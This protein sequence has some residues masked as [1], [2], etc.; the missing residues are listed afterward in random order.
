MLHTLAHA[1]TLSHTLPFPLL[2]CVSCL[3]GDLCPALRCSSPTRRAA[4]SEERR[5]TMGNAVLR[6]LGCMGKNQKKNRKENRGVKRK[7]QEVTTSEGEIQGHDEKSKELPCASNQAQDE[8]GSSSEDLCYTVIN[9][10]AQRWPSLA[11]TDHGY[12]NVSTTRRGGRRFREESETEY[13]LL[14]TAAMG[15]C[16]CTPE[17][18]YELVLPQ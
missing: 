11:S 7:R 12:E 5:E 15:P 16:S 18:D 2:C 17:H 9:H 8:A 6:A 1:C 13:A 3:P 14:R 4:K 10:A